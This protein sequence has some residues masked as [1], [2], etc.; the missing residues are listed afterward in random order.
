MSNVWLIKLKIKKI[1]YNFFF[2]YNLL[3]MNILVDAKNEYTIR[4][5]NILSP[6]ILE[7]LNSI[8]NKAKEI[9]NDDNVLKIFQSF[10]KRIPKWNDEILDSE[11]TRIKTSCKDYDL[12]Y[13]LIRASIKANLRVLIYSPF[14]TSNVKPI[15]PELYENLNFKDFIHNIY[16]EC[17]RE[18]WN[19]PYLLY[20]CYPAIDIKRNQRDTLEL[21]KKCIEESIRKSIPLN[22]VL[23]VYLGEEAKETDAKNNQFENTLTEIEVKNLKKMV[24]TDLKE[25]FIKSNEILPPVVPQS[26]VPQSIVPQ[27]IVQTRNSSEQKPRD[28]TNNSLRR[29]DLSL[30]QKGGQKSSDKG[31]DSK[32]LN[33]LDSDKLKLSED[34]EKYGNSTSDNRLKSQIKLSATSSEDIISTNMDSNLKNILKKDLGNSDTEESLSFRPENNSAKYQEVFSNSTK[35]SI[36]STQRNDEIDK[37]KFFNNYLNF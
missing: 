17:A 36:N 35:D 1:V 24:D 9:A 19:N 4:I 28:N 22:Y 34:H 12:L 25:P 18:V 10:L 37:N 23:E 15:N 20:H 30:S 33:L 21:I 6:L 5:I 2:L 3:Y 14:Q 7:G 16:I 11:V 13:N 8:Y 29:T 31:L 27:S 32:I 26:I